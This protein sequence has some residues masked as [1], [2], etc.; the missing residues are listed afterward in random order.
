M[1]FHEENH[2]CRSTLSDVIFYMLDYTSVMN[3]SKKNKNMFLPLT[4]EI[5]IHFIVLYIRA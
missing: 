4:V 5:K 3:F 2:T 1:I